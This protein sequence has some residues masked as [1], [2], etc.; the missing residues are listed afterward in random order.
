MLLALFLSILAVVLASSSQ[1]RAMAQGRLDKAISQ[2]AFNDFSSKAASACSLGE[3]NVRVFSVQGAQAAIT[4][5]GGDSIEF[6]ML[7]YS[8]NLTLPCNFGNL[9]D[10]PSSSFTIENKGG[11]IEIREPAIETPSQSP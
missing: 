10:S 6:A 4:G 2:Q 9:P 1:I 3:G 5:D 8:H 11:A 7:N